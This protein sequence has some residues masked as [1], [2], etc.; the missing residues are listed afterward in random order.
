MKRL[1][2]AIVGLGLATLACGAPSDGD[3]QTA[4]AQTAVDDSS[5][6]QTAEGEGEPEVVATLT[7]LDDPTELPP[8]E[9]PE[10]T[11][12]L[13]PTE[14]PIPTETPEPAATPVP[15]F[16]SGSGDSIVDVE[17]EPL[18]AIVHIIGNSASNHFAVI[19]L[20]SENESIDLLVNTTESYDGVHLINIEEQV[21][22]F[23]IT[24]SG[25][26]TLKISDAGAA[27]VLQSPGVYDGQNDAVL[28]IRGEPA[29]TAIIKGND[30]ANHFAVFSHG[31]SGKDLLVNTTDPYDGTV[32]IDQDVVIFEI[33]ATGSWSIEI[34]SQ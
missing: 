1:Y 13:E 18:L 34:T 29:D 12:T 30:G 6:V 21:K 33:T 11:E 3:I 24:A 17:W 16:L 26:W 9:T 5:E 23:E 7:P 15:L 10:P 4:I 2:V 22:R 27:P 28:I 14:T 8:T 25:D 19:S 32:L 31:F 20:D